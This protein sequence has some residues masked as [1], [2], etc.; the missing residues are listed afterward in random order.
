MIEFLTAWLASLPGFMTPLLLASIGLLICERAGALNLGVEGVMALGAMAGAVVVFSG[1]GPWT[2]LAAGALVGVAVSFPF[3]VAVV[4]FRAP[5][6]PAGLALV[7]I[8]LGASAALGRD[9]AHKPFPGLEATP[10]IE[11]LASLPLFGRMLFQQDGVVGLA[12]LIAGLSTWVL[13]RT[14]YGLRLRA[15]GEDPA[16][17]DAAGVDVQLYQFAALAVG[18]FL[19]GLA[20][21]YLSVAGSHTWTEGMVAG[22]GWI[23]LAL[24][25]F[26]QWSPLRAIF[27]A[28]LFGGAEAL[29]P[30]LQTLGLEVPVYFLS[31]TPYVLTIGVL[32]LISLRG[33]A[34]QVEPGFL[35]RAYIRQDR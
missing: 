14:R 28:A 25:V 31:M 7:A 1:Y 8:G 27:G 20:G 18:S 19:I 10:L 29:I 24:V 6:I 33:R 11:G 2:G 22:R 9:V 30:R 16:A 26:A 13:F 32:I 17:A 23:S 3:A 4:V 15:V 12:L 35:G 5:Q 34:R 21:A